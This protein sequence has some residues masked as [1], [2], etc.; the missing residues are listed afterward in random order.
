MQYLQQCGI[1]EDE[2]K[3]KFYVFNSGDDL[4]PVSLMGKTASF[5]ENLPKFEQSIQSVKMNNPGDSQQAL[6]AA[7]NSTTPTG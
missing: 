1:G 6:A 2:A 4:I 7:F 5:D 3:M